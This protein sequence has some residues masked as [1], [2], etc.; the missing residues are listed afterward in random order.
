MPAKTPDHSLH[1]KMIKASKDILGD[2]ALIDKDLRHQ[3]TKSANYSFQPD[4]LLKEN[5]IAVECLAIQKETLAKL[6]R[7]GNYTPRLILCIPV[8]LAVKEIW[9]FN[10]GT[11][12]ITQRIKV[13]VR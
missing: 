5:N 11:E 2:K 8:P 12:Q 1:N 7:Y 9:L 4:V 6:V 10:L 13:E 3:S